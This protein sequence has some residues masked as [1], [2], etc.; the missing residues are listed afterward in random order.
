MRLHGPVPSAW[1]ST[2]S[3]RAMRIAAEA[4]I[5]R[6]FMPGPTNPHRA[7][8]LE[9]AYHQRAWAREILARHRRRRPQDRPE[10][11]LPNVRNELIRA[12][13][14]LHTATRLTQGIQ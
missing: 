9:A 4:A 12:G 13:V 7:R 11:A 1:N 10:A 6:A 5:A 2:E 3:A 8:E 14:D